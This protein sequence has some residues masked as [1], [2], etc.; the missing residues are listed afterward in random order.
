MNKTLFIMLTA[1][2][3]VACGGSSAIVV[4]NPVSGGVDQ[5]T[6]KVAVFF[7]ES[8]KS[9]KLARGG[10][11]LPKPEPIGDILV[12]NIQTI[13]DAYFTETNF[14]T[15]KEIS[16]SDYLITFEVR[17]DTCYMYTAPI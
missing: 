14:V 9:A 17:I 1:I 2:L 13:A 8:V 16:D 3:F 15:A 11:G 7:D 4:R 5:N 6:K 12:T 10:I